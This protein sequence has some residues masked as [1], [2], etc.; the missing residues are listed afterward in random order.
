MYMYKKLYLALTLVVGLG[1]VGV[2]ILSSADCVTIIVLF[3]SAIAI[4]KLYHA[5]RT[6]IFWYDGPFMSE[7]VQIARV[8][9]KIARVLFLTNAC[10]VNCTCAA[11]GR[12]EIRVLFRIHADVLL[13][14]NTY[15]A[16]VEWLDATG[17]I[18][19]LAMYAQK[20]LPK[21]AHVE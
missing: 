15:Y 21:T 6:V 2:L 8:L 5:I 3:P 14:T 18:R 16:P 19:T 9:I 1:R 17:F 12:V 10:V 20:Q 11:T 13:T 4:T 7:F